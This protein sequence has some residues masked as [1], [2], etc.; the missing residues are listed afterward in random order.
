MLLKD[1][2]PRFDV[3]LGGPQISYTGKG[4]LESLYPGAR[5]FVRGQGEM[6]AVM[7]AMG[8]I[9]NGLYGLHVAGEQDLETRTD[10]P[11]D[12]LPSPASGR[13]LPDRQIRAMGDTTRLPVFLHVLP[14]QAVRQSSA[15]HIIKRGEITERDR[16]VPQRWNR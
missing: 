4:L 7:L 10:F 1:L 8:C 16:H 9:R 12:V 5:Y 11:L 13:H 6:A 2:V 15:E 3:V 14:A